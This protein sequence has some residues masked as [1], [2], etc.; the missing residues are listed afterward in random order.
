MKVWRALRLFTVA[1]CLVI[2]GACS[3]TKGVKVGEGGDPTQQPPEIVTGAEPAQPPGATAQVSPEPTATTTPT[4]LPVAP[5]VVPAVRE[6]LPPPA[7][8]TRPQTMPMKIA[9]VV[10]KSADVSVA[11]SP[12]KPA[13]ETP[14]V[15]QPAK[16]AGAEQI[17]LQAETL[18]AFG[19]GDAAH[20]TAAGKKKLDSI[21]DKIKRGKT[22]I[23]A[24]TV[25]G[26]ADR[27]GSLQFNQAISE[28]RAQTVKAYLVR[29]GVPG[30]IIR[31]AGRGSIHPVTD[32]EGIV[33]TK[34]LIQCLAPN[35]R[36]EVMIQSAAQ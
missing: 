19:K 14:S 11:P 29:R 31:A 28:K 18:F 20:L 24:I 12:V 34:N 36:V 2:A 4:P 15:A 6:D 9:R 16:A 1:N 30:D 3:W 32:C 33:A 21:A 13:P 8:A 26:H 27:L 17:S 23:S 25:T 7:A 10:E 5:A 35:R 22:K